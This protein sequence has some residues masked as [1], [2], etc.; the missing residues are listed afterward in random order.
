MESSHPILAFIVVLAMILSVTELPR[1]LADRISGKYRHR[2]PEGVVQGRTIVI[3]PAPEGREV[4]FTPEA[5]DELI[6][7]LKA[8]GDGVR[9]DRAKPL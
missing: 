2:E 6:G 4:Y 8:S 1:A 9:T 5:F 3:G 7:K